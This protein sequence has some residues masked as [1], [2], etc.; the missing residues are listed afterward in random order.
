MLANRLKILLAERDLSIKD[1]IEG[2]G[3]SRNVLSNM[4]NNP[5][6]N[7]STENVDKLCNFLEIDPSRFYDYLGWRF[8]YNFNPEHVT[9]FDEKVPELRVTMQSGKAI[10]SF[11]LF[12]Y[13][14]FDMD[15][16]DGIN[17]DVFIRIY[18]P[19]GYDGVFLSVYNKTTPLFR[20]Q[21]ESALLKPVQKV[22]DLAEK[23]GKFKNEN[24]KVL[25]AQIAYFYED[26]KSIVLDT[27]S[28]KRKSN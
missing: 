1:V 11:S 21:M 28:Y 7:V 14:E 16:G 15:Y 3:I 27:Y 8:T 12:Y 10:R 22:L 5:F 20:H 25:D 23:H 13:V 2:T 4:I 9:S 19:D 6:A 26:K 18:N 24:K 17:H